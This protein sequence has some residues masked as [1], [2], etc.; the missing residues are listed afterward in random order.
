MGRGEVWRGGRNRSLANGNSKAHCGVKKELGEIS[1]AELLEQTAQGDREAFA[2]FYDR[3][4]GLLFSFVIRV[5]ADPKESEDVLQE[6]FL[7]IWTKASLYRRDLGTPFNWAVTLARHK[8]IDRQRSVH[9]RSRVADVVMSE[10]TDS[11][12]SNTLMPDETDRRGNAHLVQSALQTLSM[13]QRQA[14][15]LAF[16][17]GLTQME[18]S[19][20]LREPLG[21]IKAPIRRGMLK[22]RDAL[23]P[24]L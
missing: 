6:V 11:T 15:E 10:F 9:R 13:E 19:E 1:D 18:I 14:I 22:L 2:S 20:R 4:S 5:L 8:A 24:D 7:Q 12:R 21:T 23:H 3:Y 17:N 16:F